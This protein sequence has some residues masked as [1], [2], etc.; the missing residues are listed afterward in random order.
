MKYKK[1]QTKKTNR[2]Q[3]F[4]HAHKAQIKM[5]ETIAVLLI[6]FILV[7][8]GIVFYNNYSKIAAKEK[9]EELLGMKAMDITLKSLFL[10]ELICSEGKAEPKDN[11]FDM[12]KLRHVDKVFS[13]HFEEYY[14]DLFPYTT[15][16]VEQLYPY[17]EDKE[18][19]NKNV[20]VLYDKEKPDWERKEATYFVVS[21]RDESSLIEYS[22]GVLTV[23]VYS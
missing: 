1:S 17:E 13:D 11:C 20:W 22:F 23:E 3:A 15:I 8:F 9:Q 10:P 19:N 5:S 2:L 21:L 4:I 6:F 18:G 12:M 14:F 16:T 7:V